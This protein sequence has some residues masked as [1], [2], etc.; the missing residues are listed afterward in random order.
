[1]LSFTLGPFTLAMDHLILLAS[2]LLATWSGARS[3]R[4]AGVKNPESV[5]FSLLLMALLVARLSF[6]LVYWPQYRQA[7]WQILDVRD[8]GFLLW[9]GVLALLSSAA[10]QAWR[11][12]DQRRPLAW[13]IGSGLTLWLLGT[14]TVQL[15]D[16]RQTLPDT[17]LQTLAGTPLNLRDYAGQPLV[18]NLWASWCPP[19]RREMPVLLEAARRTPGVR[20]VLVN[21]GE[22]PDQV[23]TFLA[24]AG[25][26]SQQVVFD[27]AS[28]LS[29]AAGS[30]AL[31]ATLFY[32]AQ[33]RWVRSHVG[34]LSSASLEHGLQGLLQP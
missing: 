33:G 24:A 11:R 26:D 7:P 19:C 15:H 2:L 9:P 17:P 13:A 22:S 25:I 4:A 14:L 32:D 18:V 16:R 1:M 27:R 10:W 30:A 31:P 34:E 12:P 5:L 21:Q 23:R 20:F 28:Q 29:R 8:G 3:A 6:A